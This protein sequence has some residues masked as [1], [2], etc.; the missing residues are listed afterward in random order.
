M[1]SR[2]MGTENF[3]KAAIFLSVNFGL[4][5]AAPLG[6]YV[7]EIQLQSEV[8]TFLESELLCGICP[9]EMLNLQQQGLLGLVLITN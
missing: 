9:K 3:I 4:C 5:C 8:K 6:K 1:G 7:R 2:I